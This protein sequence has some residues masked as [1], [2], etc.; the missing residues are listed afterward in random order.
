MFQ[1]LFNIVPCGLYSDKV[2]KLKKTFEEEKKNQNA[3]PNSR[4]LI[5]HYYKISGGKIHIFHECNFFSGLHTQVFFSD[6]QS[7]VIIYYYKLFQF[8]LF[9][10]HNCNQV[11]ALNIALFYLEGR[12]LNHFLQ[13]S[14]LQTH[15]L[16]PEN[17]N[18]FKVQRLAAQNYFQLCEFTFNRITKKIIHFMVYKKLLT[19]D[20]CPYE[21]PCRATS[22]SLCNQ[23]KCRIHIH[24]QHNMKTL[25]PRTIQQIGVK[26]LQLSRFISDTEYL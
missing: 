24:C 10:F 8:L 13:K 16:E 9:D 25:I 21:T 3:A 6:L 19:T 5:N 2:R 17:S 15:S 11:T 18:Q 22:L 20:F 7:K 12:I 4:E 14:Q 1:D 26:L 23:I